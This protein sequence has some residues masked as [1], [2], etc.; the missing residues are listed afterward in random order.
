MHCRCTGLQGWK[1]G[2]DWSCCLD[3]TREVRVGLEG[4]AVLG[5]FNADDVHRMFLDTRKPHSKT[6]HE[7]HDNLLSNGW[8]V[9]SSASGGSESPWLV[10]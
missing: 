7:T 3:R 5:A 4:S 2:L 9:I 1:E 8:Y 6:R 10:Q